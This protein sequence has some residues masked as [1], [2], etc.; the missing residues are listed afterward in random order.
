MW[1]GGD[2]GRE[3]A[4]VLDGGP[5]PHALVPGIE[6]RVLGK[7][8]PKDL[9]KGRDEGHDGNVSQREGVGEVLAAL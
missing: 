8:Q 1:E 9:H 5:A 6:V 4:G 3:G 7:I 2:H